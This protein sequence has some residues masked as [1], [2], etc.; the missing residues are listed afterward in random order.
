MTT[1]EFIANEEG[2][3]LEPYHDIA[4]FPTIGVGHKL[5][6]EKYADLSQWQA[7][8]REH[9]LR[10]LDGHLS[11]F[12]R[13][14]ERV[15]NFNFRVTENEMTALTC[16]AFNIGLGALERSE[17]AKMIN[18][19]ESTVAITLEWCD[20]CKATIGGHKQVV[21][22]LLNRRRREVALYFGV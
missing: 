8:T 14:V 13:G 16:L 12:K 19:D 17:L 3:R 22:G 1:A 11:H 10:Q 6:G 18:A 7:I 9:A 15:I 4:G 20:W 21:E 2:L 5:S